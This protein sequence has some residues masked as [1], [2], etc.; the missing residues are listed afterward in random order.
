MAHIVSSTKDFLRKS[1]RL[2]KVRLKS[3]HE[4]QCGPSERHPA[5]DSART[6]FPA[7]GLGRRASARSRRVGSHAPAE[8]HLPPISIG[9]EVDFCTGAGPTAPPQEGAKREKVE[10]VSSRAVEAQK[11][12]NG[13]KA[14]P[15]CWLRQV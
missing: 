4:R 14:M 10:D 11:A 3:V 13:R 1:P 5:A 6:S 15:L 12:K 2:F 7:A 9:L 8:K